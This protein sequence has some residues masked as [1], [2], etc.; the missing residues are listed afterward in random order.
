MQILVAIF[1]F[2]LGPVICVSLLVV[3]KITYFK[4]KKYV[5]F[6]ALFGPV[7]SFFDGPSPSFWGNIENKWQLGKHC[8]IDLNILSILF[9]KKH[10]DSA[11]RKPPFGTAGT[12][13]VALEALDQP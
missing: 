2:W 4:K 12:T 11:T 3:V 7:S 13:S 10:H 6:S 8:S 5:H 1:A 9:R